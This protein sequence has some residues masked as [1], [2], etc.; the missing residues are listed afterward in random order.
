MSGL[1]LPRSGTFKALKAGDMGYHRGEVDRM[2]AFDASGPLGVLGFLPMYGDRERPLGFIF[3]ARL[4]V[5]LL[6]R[7]EVSS[8]RSSGG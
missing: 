6:R 3:C 1:S 7:G 4:K 8:S 2:L 5:S